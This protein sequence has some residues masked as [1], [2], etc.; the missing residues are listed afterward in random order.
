MIKLIFLLCFTI[1]SFEITFSQVTNT[2]LMDTTSGL[3][4]GPVGLSAYIDAYYA[5]DFN[6]PKNKEIPYYV[7][8][9]N[10]NTFNIN[11]AYLDIKYNGKRVRARF[12]PAFGTYMN[13]NYTNEKGGL[14]Y[15]LEGSIG[16][17][18]S[19]KK[20]IW[21]DAGI[22]GS[23]YT[24][25]SAISKDHLMYSRSLSAE[26][27]PYY[28]CGVKFGLPL[29]KKINFYTYLINGWQ[30]INDQ[31]NGKS[32]GTQLEWKWNNQNI[33]NWDTYV[34]DERSALNPNHRIRYFT[35]LYWIHKGKKNWDFTSCAY[36]GLQERVNIDKR[37]IKPWWQ[38]NFIARYTFVKKFSLSAR[39]EYYE[40]LNGST[41]TPITSVQQFKC[42]GS[43]LSFA[44]HFIEN[45]MFRVEAKGLVSDKNIF[46]SAQQNST[47]SS[48]Q[49]FGNLTV[50]F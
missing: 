37:E 1:L 10:H 8:S 9:N 46:L 33:L 41:L 42:F 11:L 25:E 12:V 39:V 19:K 43:G 15:I 36:L 22:L 4:I 2:G 7:S 45:C 23:P 20:E 3:K 48:L 44:W 6:Q 30:Q 32:I 24:N 40:D 29:S 27:V 16:V 50:W 14:K 47:N 31:N 26:N 38:A 28:L 34:G 17:K 49:V 18:L 5:F 13:A 35:D 21:L